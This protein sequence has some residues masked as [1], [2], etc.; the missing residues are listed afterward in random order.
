M[1][2]CC[3]PHSIL[4]AA[5][6]SRSWALTVPSNDVASVIAVD[7]LYRGLKV[8]SSRCHAMITKV[9]AYARNQ[10][11]L[12]GAG[13]C[14]DALPSKDFDGDRSLANALDSA[15]SSGERGSC[16][17]PSPLLPL[18]AAVPSAG[19]AATAGKPFAAT[20]AS[21]A[22][23]SSFLMAAATAD[24]PL[25]LPPPL[26]EKPVEAARREGGRR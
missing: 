5:M 3:R 2:I 25:P 23:N 21:G 1:Q 15:E 22:A 8:L 12:T 6:V 4:A 11:L 14:T 19:E 18:A 13:C 9:W 10:E 17:C 26:A 24:T 7:Y 20:E 16:G